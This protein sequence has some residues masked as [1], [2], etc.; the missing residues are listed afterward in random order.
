MRQSEYVSPYKPE[1]EEA[2]TDHPDCDRCSKALPDWTGNVMV[3]REGWDDGR[4][5]L[6]LRVWCK[7]CTREADAALGIMNVPHAMWELS[8]LKD[9]FPYTLDNVLSTLGRGGYN[10][11][12]GA[13][14][15]L[16]H[17]ANMVLIPGEHEPH[18]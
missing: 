1:Y 3:S 8:W 15:D 12:S 10:W 6:S 2:Y 4:Q 5:I 17:L 11:S 7:E 16:R 18:R 9:D 13:I 14:E